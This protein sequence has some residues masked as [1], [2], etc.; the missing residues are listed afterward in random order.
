[1]GHAC[2][3]TPLV[4]TMGALDAQLGRSYFISD[5]VRAVEGFRGWE[6]SEHLWIWGRGLMNLLKRIDRTPGVRRTW[7]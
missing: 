3:E 5:A 6:K 2:W 7:L 4:S 1:M